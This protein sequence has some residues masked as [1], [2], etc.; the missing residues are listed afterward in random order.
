MKIPIVVLLTDEDEDLVMR[1]SKQ[2][3]DGDGEDEHDEPSS[4][5]R[6]T[7][8]PHAHKAVVL[9]SHNIAQ[10]TWNKNVWKG[11]EARDGEIFFKTYFKLKVVQIRNCYLAR[12]IKQGPNNS[13]I[14]NNLRKKLELTNINKLYFVYGHSTKS[15]FLSD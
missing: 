13:E 7:S 6:G 8:H 10:V 9:T 15:Q 14:K 2:H 3:G 11:E 12:W 4:D 5:V 1:V